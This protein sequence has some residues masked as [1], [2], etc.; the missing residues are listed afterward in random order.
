MLS[1]TL[2]GCGGSEGVVVAHR[3]LWWLSL[4]GCGGSVKK[5]QATNPVVL[6]SNPGQSLQYQKFPGYCKVAG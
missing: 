6:G 1:L 3:G 2:G 4:G 5:R